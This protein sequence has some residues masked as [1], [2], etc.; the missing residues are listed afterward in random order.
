MWFKDKAIFVRMYQLCFNSPI[1]HLGARASSP[2][3]E[4]AASEHCKPTLSLRRIISVRTWILKSEEERGPQ[5]FYPSDHVLCEGSSGETVSE[6]DWQFIF[7]L[8][9]TSNWFD[10]MSSLTPSTKMNCIIERIENCFNFSTYTGIGKSTNPRFCENED[11]KLRSSACC[12]Q[13]NTIF[14]PLIL[15]TWGLWICRS[16]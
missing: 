8:P 4:K 6:D 10:C 2:Y 15:G 9:V 14:C 5:I 13:E 11:K 3:F 16:Q 12:R 7:T 1:R